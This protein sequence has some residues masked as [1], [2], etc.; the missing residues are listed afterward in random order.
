MPPRE[1]MLEY[2]TYLTPGMD[3]YYIE[4]IEHQNKQELDVM[5]TPPPY[6]NNGYTDMVF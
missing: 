3:I 4:I 6:T 5:G 2:L 1:N